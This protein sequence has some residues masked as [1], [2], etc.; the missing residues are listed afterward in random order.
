MISDKRE[1]FTLIEAL[2]ALLII[3]ISLVALLAASST[4]SNM[5]SFISSYFSPGRSLSNYAYSKEVALTVAEVLMKKGYG[6]ELPDPSLFSSSDVVLNF[7]SI[8]DI[9][10]GGEKVAEI[11][12]IKVKYMAPSGEWKEYVHY[13]IRGNF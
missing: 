12:P 4:I 7:G 9:N 8:T 3:S 1:G 6:T 10:V 5:L 11:I 2:V 13:V